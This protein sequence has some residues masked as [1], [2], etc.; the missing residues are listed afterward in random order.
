MICLLVSDIIPHLPGVILKTVQFKPLT[1]FAEHTQLL[2]NDALMGCHNNQ[3]NQF[4]SG[5]IQ[6]NAPSS[7]EQQLGKLAKILVHDLLTC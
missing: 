2:A 3:K 7:Q 6:M 5:K 4:L 1:R